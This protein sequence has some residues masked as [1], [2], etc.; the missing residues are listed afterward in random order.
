M[1]KKKVHPMQ[2]VQDFSTKYA[3]ISTHYLR[4]EGVSYSMIA[5]TLEECHYVREEKTG[6]SKT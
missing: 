2:S 6:K 5:K 1:N 3:T 4:Q